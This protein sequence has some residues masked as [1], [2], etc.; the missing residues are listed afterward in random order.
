ML[1]V[2]QQLLGVVTVFGL[3]GGLL[4]WMRSRGLAQF[5]GGSRAGSGRRL[6]LAERLVLGPQHSLHLVRF[7]G[8]T[9]LVATAPGQCAIMWGPEGEPGRSGSAAEGRIPQSAVSPR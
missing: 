3:L 6:E 7:D 9:L 2:T 8:R 5:A 4:W 1:D